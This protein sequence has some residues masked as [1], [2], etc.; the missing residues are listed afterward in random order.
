MKTF[1]KWFTRGAEFIAAM[2]LAAIFI[3]FLLQIVFRYVPFLTHR[4]V[5]CADFIALGFRD[6]L[7]MLFHRARTGPRNF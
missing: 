5:G 3:T 6:L 1:S 4:L 7:R 2:S